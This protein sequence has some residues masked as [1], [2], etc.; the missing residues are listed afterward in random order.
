M[1]ADL[2]RYDDL[3]DVDQYPDGVILNV[4]DPGFG[5]KRDRA[6][7]KGIPWG[8]Y[9]WVYPGDGVGAVQRAHD[10][11]T[12]PLGAWLDYEQ[13]GVSP[14][15]LQAALAHADGLGFK[16]G[17]YTYLYILPSVVGLLGD[18]PLWLA[19]YPGA[20]DGTYQAWYS[21]DARAHGAL[22]HQFTSS[23]GTR[24]L[25]VVLDEARW[26]AWTGSVPT[27][28][29]DD[30]VKIWIAKGDG[31]APQPAYRF[32]DDGPG[33]VRQIVS[34]EEAFGPVLAAEAYGGSVLTDKG[35]P[36]VWPQKT[37]DAVPDYVPP[38]A[39]VFTD[40]QIKK[41]A[42]AVIDPQT[43]AKAVNDDAAARLAS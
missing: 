32:W 9:S 24:D 31:P 7:T 39:P 10:V 16:I 11:G 25:S 5:A 20:N 41:I 30:D 6:I 28:P 13:G 42:A 2:S 26:S 23:N 14:A 4:E 36:F 34:L 21:N 35:Q 19:Y 3:T 43:V 12:G 33:M 15:D 27:L 1:I 38:T 17:V 37:V 29:E 18:H 40:A 22:L 8:T